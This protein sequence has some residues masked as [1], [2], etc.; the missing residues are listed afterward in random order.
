MGEHNTEYRFTDIGAQLLFLF[1][2]KLLDTFTIKSFLI[3]C[4]S[5]LILFILVTGVANDSLGL[6]VQLN[7]ISGKQLVHHIVIINA[8]I[9]HFLAL[10]YVL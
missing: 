1:C 7:T 6:T 8:Y 4:L 10:L 9:K 3:L 2:E 5:L